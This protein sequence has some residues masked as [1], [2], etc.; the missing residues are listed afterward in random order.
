MAKSTS[1]KPYVR[2]QSNT[3]ICVTAGLQ[4]QDVTNPDAHVPDRL[5][6]NPIWP[7]LTVLIKKGAGIYPSYIAEWNT[8]KALARDKILTIGEYL[9][10][11]AEDVNNEVK[12]VKEQLE[13]SI[14][15]IELRGIDLSKLAGE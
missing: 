13:Q 4:A 10:S 14:K 1:T 12:G 7:K 11:D 8:V 2:I 3:D 5:K 9:D 15:E 6:V